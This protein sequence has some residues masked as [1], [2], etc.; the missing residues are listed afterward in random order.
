MIASW[1]D[2]T[3]LYSTT[4]VKYQLRDWTETP[5]QVAHL[6]SKWLYAEQLILLGI[7]PTEFYARSLKLTE[8]G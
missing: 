4:T 3:G 2:R 8:S 1:K 6:M 5:H 7:Q